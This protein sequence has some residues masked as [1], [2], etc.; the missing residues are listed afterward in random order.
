MLT[1]KKIMK[2]VTS[3]FQK[4]KYS[5]FVRP[6]EKKIQEKFVRKS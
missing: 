4:S 2:L 5:T 6:T 1:K 3:K